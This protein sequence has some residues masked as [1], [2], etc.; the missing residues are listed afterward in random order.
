ML[1][2]VDAGIV[3]DTKT[4][5]VDCGVCVGASQHKLVASIFQTILH[6][7]YMQEKTLCIINDIR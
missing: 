4:G 2:V 3:A 6:I 5:W 1:D 7:F